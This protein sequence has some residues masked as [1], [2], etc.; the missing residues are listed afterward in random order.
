MLS[1]ASGA[2]PWRVLE[3]APAALQVVLPPCPAEPRRAKPVPAASQ[4]IP[5][6]SRALP[7]GV[8]T[9]L[10]PVTQ[11]VLRLPCQV[12]PRRVLELVHAASLVQALPSGAQPRRV[13]AR[14]RCFQSVNSAVPSSAFSDNQRAAPQELPS[15]RPP[16]LSLPCRA[17]LSMVM[18]EF[19][20]VASLVPPLSSGALPTLLQANQE[21]APEPQELPQPGQA[22]L[23]LVI[24]ELAP[25]AAHAISLLNRALP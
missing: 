10:A 2:Q 19:V 15:P 5:P 11:P 4:E 6:P 23:L 14:A 3:L 25:T 22:L 16:V 8:N 9:E 13:R 7:P 18:K 20:P 21:L 1:L 12:Q 24:N 17:F